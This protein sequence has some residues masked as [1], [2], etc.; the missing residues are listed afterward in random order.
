M[1]GVKRFEDGYYCLGDGKSHIDVTKDEIDDLISTLVEDED[2]FVMGAHRF[3]KR[4]CPT[5]E[6]AVEAC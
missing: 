5:K 1:I 3:Y 6:A 4:C 2:V